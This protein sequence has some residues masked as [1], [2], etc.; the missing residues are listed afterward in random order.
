MKLVVMLLFACVLVIVMAQ[1][2]HPA[3]LRFLW[4]AGETPV[5][6]LISLTALGGFILGI[7]TTLLLRSRKSPRT[8]GLK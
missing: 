8:P 4:F 5:V 3:P 7:L 2:T 6:L 1:N